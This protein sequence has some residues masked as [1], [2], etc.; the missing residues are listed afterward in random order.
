LLTITPLL[1]M[2]AAPAAA[3]DFG[4]NK[5]QYEKFHFSVLATEH[6]DIYYY[7]DEAQAAREM[8]RLAER[9]YVRL[10]GLLTHQLSS[11]QAVVLY[12]SHPDFEQ[13]NVIEG[14]LDEGTGGVT[15]SARRRVVLPMAGSLADSDHVLGHELVHAFQYDILG[16]NVEGLPLWFIEGMAEYL[17]L[18]PRD[19]QTA[20]WLRDAALQGRLPKITDLDDPRYFPYRFGHAFWAYI[21]GLRGD[22]VIG[23]ILNALGPDATGGAG[24]ADVRLAI[25]N[26]EGATEKTKEE[27]SDAWHAAIYQ[28]YGITPPSST[29]QVSTTRDRLVIGDT[30][31]PGALNVGPA[32][33]PDGTRI[34]YLSASSRISI[35]LYLADAN[36]GRTIRHLIRTAGDPHFESL[37]FLA[38]AGGWA[39]DNRRLA[40]ATVRKGRPVLAIIDTDNGKVTQEITIP[41][42]DE[43]F[44]PSWSPDGASIA[45]SAQAGGF[46]DLFVHTLS[47]GATR[48]LTHDEFAD[49]HPAWSPDGSRIAFVTDRGTG[50]LDTL[51]FKGHGLAT[52]D[53]SDGRIQ[54]LSTGLSGNA[55]NPQWSH[56]GRTI[57]FIADADGRPN[58]YRLDVQSGRSERL[59]D[60]ATGIVGITPTS[61]ALSVAATGRAAVSLFRNS[62]YEI[63]FI[64]LPE[65]TPVESDARTD[66]ARLPPVDRAASTVAA[67]LAQPS[68]LAAPS[69]LTEEPYKP[70]FG[71]VE[72]GQQVG[73]STSSTFG[74]AV[75]GG[76]GMAFSDILGNHLL[77]VGLA[78]NGGVRDIGGSVSYINRT[79]RWNW[80]VFGERLPLLSG[81][82]DTFISSQNGQPVIV[83]NT[84]LF[85]QT[86]TQ[87]GA[88]V[89][90]PFS[91]SSRIEFQGAAQHIGFTSDVESLIFDPFSGNLIDRIT[92]TDEVAP[93]L[94]LFNTTGSFVRD[95]AAFGAVSP[96]IGQRVRL[97]VTR[98][99]G[100]LSFL[101]L[102][103]DAR[104]YVMPFRPLT[105]AGRALH[106][107][108][109]GQDVNDD[110]LFPLYLG[111][112]TLVRGY[113]SNSFQPEECGLSAVGACPTFDRLFGDQIFVVNLEARVPVVG[114]FN[115]KLDYGP[116]PLELFTFFDA[117]LAWTSDDKPSFAGGSRTW[118]KS[119]G[120]G[121]RVNLLG[122]AI[123]EFNL[124]RP[125]DRPERGW[126]FVFNFRPGY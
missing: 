86:Y 69:T 78:V 36:T 54:P 50:T 11:R 74:T 85:R 3:Q 42:A 71:L 59:T 62:G 9:W 117:G 6:F 79:N 1:T 33:S 5:V 90:Y 88:L 72:I 41:E 76:I 52:I 16:Q 77:N 123:G 96:I 15:E 22:A 70:R 66:L 73:V 40:V 75:S 108:R 82:V 39:P 14:E 43:I 48:R 24:R 110:R 65:M 27:L 10:S 120:F 106:F 32:I 91:R 47:T 58:V 116:L 67:L 45:F 35:D 64:D 93:S 61:P 4:R 84:E 8:G 107:G 81:T 104:Q 111:Y 124:A 105:L 87:T 49:M 7:P 118:V 21:G 46:T 99:S 38:S 114:L 37:Q 89:A 103:E 19:T 101:E 121:A 115:G 126:L 17:S 92:N 26:I 28:T 30:S 98:T 80:G 2:A 18:G 113:D 109:F 51:L 13:T 68:G 119:A 112:P 122:F 34:A 44:Q 97:D 20:M 83:Q 31:E 56:D 55:A 53:V 100:D 60:S 125:L 95:T 57:W 29:R 23:Q 12:A 63:Q 25:G 102:S 94:T